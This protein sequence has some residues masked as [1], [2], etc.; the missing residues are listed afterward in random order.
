MVIGEVADKFVRHSFFHWG[1]L[2]PTNEAAMSK[3][4]PE[5]NQEKI[6]V[7]LC[8]WVAEVKDKATQ[9]GELRRIAEQVSETAAL[10]DAD[11]EALIA[12]ASKTCRS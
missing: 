2:S 10:N 7:R 6:F 12:E 3:Q 8:T 5:K 4:L 1:I 9:M 11:A